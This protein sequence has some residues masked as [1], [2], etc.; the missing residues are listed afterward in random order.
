MYIWYMLMVSDKHAKACFGSGCYTVKQRKLATNIQIYNFDSLLLCD[1][2]T[3]NLFSFLFHP[4]FKPTI[5]TEWKFSLLRQSSCK[6]L[7]L[8]WGQTIPTNSHIRPAQNHLQFQSSW[9]KYFGHF[10]CKV[11]T[12]HAQTHRQSGNSCRFFENKCRCPGK[13]LLEDDVQMWY[14]GSQAAENAWSSQ[15]KQDRLLF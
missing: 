15:A 4:V 3:H 11:C 7:E 8:F 9:G 1:E 2:K 14:I 5:Y 12:R 10:T 13:M 6:I